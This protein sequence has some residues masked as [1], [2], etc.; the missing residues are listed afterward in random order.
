MNT[1][2]PLGT[3]A[4]KPLR[5][6]RHRCHELLDTMWSDNT[7]RSQLYARLA[8]AMGMPEIHIA[9]CNEEECADVLEILEEGKL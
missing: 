9:E 7:T 1:K 3:L 6:L 4:K 2:L 8:L 5:K